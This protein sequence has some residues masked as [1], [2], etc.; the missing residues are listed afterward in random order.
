MLPCGRTVPE[1]N[2]SFA[3]KAACLFQNI[4]ELPVQLI[5]SKQQPQKP[6]R[7][8][9]KQKQQKN[10]AYSLLTLMYPASG[11]YPPLISELAAHEQYSKNSSAQRANNQLMGDFFTHQLGRKNSI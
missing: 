2:Q 1:T 10:S 11:R 6:R 5:T 9:Y 8:R 7:T 4:H 3:A